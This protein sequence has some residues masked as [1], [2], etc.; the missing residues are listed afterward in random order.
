MKLLI[1]AFLYICVRYFNK[2]G[3]KQIQHTKLTTH[4]NDLTI[5]NERDFFIDDFKF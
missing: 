5:K 1:G 4:A 2:S 3:E